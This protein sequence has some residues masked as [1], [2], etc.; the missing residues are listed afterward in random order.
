[1]FP[2]KRIKRHGLVE[3]VLS[4]PLNSFIRPCASNIDF[5]PTPTSHYLIRAKDIHVALRRALANS[6]S[7]YNAPLGHVHRRLDSLRYIFRGA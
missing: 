3:R 4:L 7:D 5:I 1:V 2:K 6:P